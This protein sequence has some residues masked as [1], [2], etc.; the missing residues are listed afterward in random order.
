MHHGYKETQTNY[1]EM[2]NKNMLCCSCVREVEG[3][4]II[5]ETQEEI[6]NNAAVL[7]FHNRQSGN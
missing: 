2:H 6:T 3:P 4:I 1:R 7:N 5:H